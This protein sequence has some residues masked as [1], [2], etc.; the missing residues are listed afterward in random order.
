M[1]GFEMQEVEAINGCEKEEIREVGI[2]MKQR[3]HVSI[4]RLQG[5]RD[6]IGDK[7]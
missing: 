1:E 2:K 3:A 6:A 4:F 5:W 7:E